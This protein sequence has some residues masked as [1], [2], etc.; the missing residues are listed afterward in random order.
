MELNV[1]R[2][3]GKFCKNNPGFSAFLHGIA[4]TVF[5]IYNPLN[6]GKTLGLIFKIVAFCP[7]GLFLAILRTRSER[8]PPPGK[9]IYRSL[10]ETVTLL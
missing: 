1:Y 6:F 5:F 3:D 4:V 7:Q 9:L 10:K 8:F 2:K